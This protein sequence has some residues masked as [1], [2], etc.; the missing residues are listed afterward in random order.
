MAGFQVS[1]E[2]EAS[3]ANSLPLQAQGNRVKICC[4]HL[5]TPMLREYLTIAGWHRLFWS[6]AGG[7]RMGWQLSV[8]I[9]SVCR[10]AGPYASANRRPGNKFGVTAVRSY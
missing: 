2:G 10:Q 5:A 7:A 9:E 1:T 6:G 4:D 8:L 3:E